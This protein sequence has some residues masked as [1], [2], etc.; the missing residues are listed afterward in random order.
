MFLAGGLSRYGIDS[1]A[2]G[3][4]QTATLSG[5]AAVAMVYLFTAIFGA[6]WLT[7]P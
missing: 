2:A 5:N 1:R 7:V 3:N 6:T 4:L